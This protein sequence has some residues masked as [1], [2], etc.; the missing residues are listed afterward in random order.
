MKKLKPIFLCSIINHRIPRIKA[1]KPA[2]AIGINK[3]PRK[4]KLKSKN[5]HDILGIQKRTQGYIFDFFNRSILYNHTIHFLLTRADCSRDRSPFL[6]S[7]GG[8]HAKI[9]R[10]I[11]TCSLCYYEHRLKNSPFR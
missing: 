4:E 10:T 2:D 11:P 6:R 1:I 9:I 7:E 3:K 5:I 8:I